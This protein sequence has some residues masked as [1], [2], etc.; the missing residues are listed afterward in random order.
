MSDEPVSVA[1]VAGDEVTRCGLAALL[2]GDPRVRRLDPVASL[3][4]LYKADT[5][6]DVC[7]LEYA[8]SRV[9]EIES[10]ANDDVPVL[11]WA[12]TSDWRPLVA[13]WVWGARMVVGASLGRGS[14]I[15]A[16]LDAVYRPFIIKP[17]LAGALNDAVRECR[18]PVPQFLPELL[19]DVHRGHSVV[20]TMR[21]HGLDEAEFA[22]EL[23][24]L[25]GECQ[26]AGLGQVTA[27]TSVGRAALE[28][29]NVP[30][31]A[32]N[33]TA[34]TRMALELYADGNDYDS[35]AKEMSISPL[36]VRNLIDKALTRFGILPP[37]RAEVRLLFAI[38]L[39]GRHR[40]PDRLRRRLYA[41]RDGDSQGS[42]AA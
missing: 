30:P 27:R 11:V 7:L 26:E 29:S 21:V 9:A 10:L 16:A 36:T 3:D 33:F 39:S 28:P 19:F 25:R 23:A 18:L 15:D 37:R 31:D 6:F 12:K 40:R 4:A 2:V 8:E 13:A 34:H 32:L 41:L 35:V 24:K 1:I 14:L 22:R 38:W 17:Q 20:Q 42:D 5:H